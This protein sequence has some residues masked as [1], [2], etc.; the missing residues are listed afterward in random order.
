VA[1]RTDI[2]VEANR[3][4]RA[5]TAVPHPWLPSC[6]DRPPA[7]ASALACDV[8]LASD[9]AL[10]LAER[11]PA[12]EALACGLISAVYPSDDFGAQVDKVV[13]ARISAPAVAFAK[14][15]EAVNAATLTK[16]DSA[17]ERE[18]QG[19][20][21]CYDHTISSRAQRHSSSGDRRTS[22]IRAPKG[23]TTAAARAPRPGST[24]SGSVSAPALRRSSGARTRIPSRE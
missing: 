17:L 5:I 22:P 4:I 13:S 21:S 16:L 11:L 23:R 1:A 8:V 15:K 10:L 24:R 3:A 18:L 9:K 7:S 19:Q 20:G 14:T 2:I 6:K 12:A